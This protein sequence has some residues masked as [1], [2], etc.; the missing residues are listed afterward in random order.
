MQLFSDSAT[1][2]HFTPFEHKRLQPA[3]RQI[4]S[5]NQD[6]YDHRQQL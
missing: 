6:H 5:G 4:T 2:N 3:L 1:A